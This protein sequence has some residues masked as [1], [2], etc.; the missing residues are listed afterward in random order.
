LDRFNYKPSLSKRG[1][2]LWKISKPG[3]MR[4]SILKASEPP[5]DYVDVLAGL[6][7]WP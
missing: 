5:R 4:F 2:E 3:I 1:L 7:A 6:G